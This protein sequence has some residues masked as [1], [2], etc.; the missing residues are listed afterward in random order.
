M[1]ANLVNVRGTELLGGVA[2]EQPAG[3]PVESQ[4]EDSRRG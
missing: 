2:R 3:Y 1:S 4:W